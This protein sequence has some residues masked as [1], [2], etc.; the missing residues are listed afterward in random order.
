MYSPVVRPGGLGCTFSSCHERWGYQEACWTVTGR[1][2]GTDL[3][4]RY[5]SLFEAFVTSGL[6]SGEHSHLDSDPQ[7]QAVCHPLGQKFRQLLVWDLVP[8]LS[9]WA[10]AFRAD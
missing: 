9:C 6:L 3:T 10:E 7:L 2:Q 5:D 1:Y 8:A 4:S